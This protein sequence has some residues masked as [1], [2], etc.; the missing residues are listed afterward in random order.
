[1]LLLDQVVRNRAAWQL[2]GDQR[3][4]SAPDLRAA[5]ISCPARYALD[6]DV[7][8]FTRDL[9][10]SKPDLLAASVDIQRVPAP[11]LCIEWTEEPC[12]PDP[13]VRFGLFV[14]VAQNGQL[15][16]KIVVYEVHDHEPE[17]SPAPFAFDFDTIL[18]GAQT[19]AR[20]GMSHD[21][22]PLDNFFA[23]VTAVIDPQ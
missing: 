21:R 2:P 23:H 11:Q 7:V 8:Q 22:L 15:G 16:E 9:V 4:P 5:L 6:P 18:K 19:G 3:I 12:E 17:I 13:P 1:M 20:F 10:L 14:K